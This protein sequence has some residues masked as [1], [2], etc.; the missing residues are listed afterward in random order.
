MKKVKAGLR[1]LTIAQTVISVRYAL[2]CLEGNPNFPNLPFPVSELRNDVN[3]LDEFEQH[4]KAGNLTLKA[5][6][7]EIRTLL[8]FKISLT[9]NY[10][11]TLAKGDLGVLASSGF[12]LAKSGAPL[13]TPGAIQKIS[14]IPG[15]DSGSCKVYWSGIKGRSFYVVQ[16]TRNPE[17]ESSWREV[18]HVTTTSCKVFNLNEGTRFYFRVC[19]I[20]KAGRGEWSEIARVMA[21]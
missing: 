17:N 18:N 4:Y 16:M 14:A 8:R 5:Q 1:G 12:E 9:G 10:I 20:N 13:G 11:N 15:P 6:R 7:D 2:T 3:A 21:A 19:A